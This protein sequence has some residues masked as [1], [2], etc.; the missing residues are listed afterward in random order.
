ML[1]HHVDSV[2]VDMI[3]VYEK[4]PFEDPDGG[5]WKQGFLIET[6]DTEWAQKK[7]RGTFVFYVDILE[8]WFSNFFS[9]LLEIV[10]EPHLFLKQRIFKNC[11]RKLTII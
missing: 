3:N 5:V 8:K 11:A 6:S 1:P 4:L 2:D 10:V 7:L 9:V